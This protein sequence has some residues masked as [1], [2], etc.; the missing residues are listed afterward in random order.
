MTKMTGLYEHLLEKFTHYSTDELIQFNNDTVL[1]QGWGSAK[2]TFRAALLRT[3]SK[4]GFD[5]SEIISN[6]D[7]FISLKNV[8]VRLEKNTL[9]PI[10]TQ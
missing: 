6:E 10:T 4:R 2:F 7:G 8:A 9:I 3:F 5:L 1:G